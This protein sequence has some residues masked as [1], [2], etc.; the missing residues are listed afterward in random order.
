NWNSYQTVNNLF[1]EAISNVVKDGDLVWV[2]DYHFMLLPRMLRE[3]VE[4]LDGV[5]NSDLIGFHTY[6]YA[7]HFLSSCT[8]ILELNAMPNRI[9]FEGRHVHVGTFPVGI[10]PDRFAEGL[11]QPKIQQRIKALEERFKG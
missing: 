7:R 6:D 2:Q 8:R 3:K 10:D 9:D 4:V 1:A 11:K 5:L